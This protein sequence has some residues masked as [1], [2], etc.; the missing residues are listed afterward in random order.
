[1]TEIVDN[2]RVRVVSEAQALPNAVEADALV[3][4]RGYMEWAMSKLDPIERDVLR[5]TKGLDDGVRRSRRMV[6]KMLEMRSSQAAEALDPLARAG[7]GAPEPF[8][9][10]VSGGLCWWVQS[11]GAAGLLRRS[12][13]RQPCSATCRDRV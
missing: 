6:A 8:R 13:L 10:M 7:Y 2:T 9:G 1:M 5:L 12:R 11:D 4:L 3:K